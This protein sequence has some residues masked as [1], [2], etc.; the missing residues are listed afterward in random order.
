MIVR[1]RQQIGLARR[2]P[3]PCRGTLALRAVPVAAG[4]GR[5]PLAALWA[6][7]VM[8]SWRP[9]ALEGA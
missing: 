2:Q 8:G 9:A 3:V 5:C 7:S 4:N 1:H 6:N